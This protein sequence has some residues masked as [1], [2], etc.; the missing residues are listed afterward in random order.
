MGGATLR[1]DSLSTHSSIPVLYDAFGEDIHA[2]VHLAVVR[3]DTV[4]KGILQASTLARF[5]RLM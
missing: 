3:D 2:A 1:L 5:N 4:D